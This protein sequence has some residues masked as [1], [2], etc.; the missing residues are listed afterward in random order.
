MSPFICV[1]CCTEFPPS[2]NPPEICPICADPRQY[3]NPRGQAWTTQAELA[4]AHKSDLRQEEPGLLGI[5][6]TPQAGIG[7]R[8]LLIEHEQGGILWDGVPLLDDA[9]ITEIKKRGGVRAMVMSHPHLYGAMITNSQK[10]GNV[11]IYIPAAD[12][13]WIMYPH[14]NIHLLDEDTYDLGFGVTLHVTGGHFDGS[15]FVHWPQGADGKGVLLTGDT[16]QVAADPNWAS[17]MWSTPNLVQLNPRAI[18]KIV[19]IAEKLDYDRIYAGWWN[20]VM[21]DGAKVKIAASEQRI[22]KTLGLV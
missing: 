21:R 19:A 10:L 6:V 17:F 16:I 14:D 11:P 1:T 18:R 4:K 22:L 2:D 13:E 7:Q 20:T 9:A 15:A 5:G 8:A 12:R 3:I